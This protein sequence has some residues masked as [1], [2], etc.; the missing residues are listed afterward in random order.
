[1]R[2]HG[3]RSH[4]KQQK[5]NSPN[6]SAKN[7]GRYQAS[8]GCTIFFMLHTHRVPMRP[9]ACHHRKLWQNT[10][11]NIR[12]MGLTPFTITLVRRFIES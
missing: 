11:Q 5:N 3:K 2:W 10:G 4:L 12:I 6:Q 8:L 1:V 9:D 7:S